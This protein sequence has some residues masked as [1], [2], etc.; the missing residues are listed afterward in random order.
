V[1]S[2]SVSTAS[3]LSAWVQYGRESP[4]GSRRCKWHGGPAT[5]AAAAF[6][7]LPLLGR[8]PVGWLGH[9]GP[10]LGCAPG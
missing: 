5:G 7:L 9:G 3:G 2:G 8:L 6:E 10:Q 4:T 1:E